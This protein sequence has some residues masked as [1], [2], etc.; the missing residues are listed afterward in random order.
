MISRLSVLHTEL[1]QPFVLGASDRTDHAVCFLLPVSLFA[2]A[3]PCSLCCRSPASSSS[4]A[5]PANIAILPSRACHRH[6]PGAAVPRSPLQSITIVR[7]P[8]TH[9]T[10]VTLRI[11]SADC[12]DYDRVC[13]PRSSQSQ[14][15]ERIEGGRNATVPRHWRDVSIDLDVAP[16]LAKRRHSHLGVFRDSPR[17]PVLSSAPLIPP[18]YWRRYLSHARGSTSDTLDGQQR[19]TLW[20]SSRGQTLDDRLLSC[21]QCLPAVL[22][23]GFRSRRDS[24]CDASQ[25]SRLNESVAKRSGAQKQ[26]GH[27]QPRP[28]PPAA[29]A[30][31]GVR[32]EMGRGRTSPMHRSREWGNRAAAAVSESLRV[33][34]R[35]RTAAVDSTASS[36]VQQSRRKHPPAAEQKGATWVAGARE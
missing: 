4:S 6:R 33:L 20:Q 16:E 30:A 1:S 25:I 28:S 12:I 35:L 21:L 34:C 19:Q 8:R 29:E 22:R 27:P 32:R 23:S 2:C 14:V 24:C 7:P 18:A 3:C 9:S 5:A 31:T 17:A 15:E 13:G 26:H 11:R 10:D 36:T